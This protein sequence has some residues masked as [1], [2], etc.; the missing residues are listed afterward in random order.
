MVVRGKGQNWFDT[1]WLIMY[2]LFTCCRNNGNKFI[3]A[4]PHSSSQSINQSINESFLQLFHSFFNSS[5]P[6]GPLTKFN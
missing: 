3:R 1:F 6:R 4:F 5:H 2:F